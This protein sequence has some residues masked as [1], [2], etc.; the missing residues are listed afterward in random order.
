MKRGG[1]SLTIHP[2][3]TRATTVAHRRWALSQGPWLARTHRPWAFHA[4]RYAVAR[5]PL[6]VGRPVPPATTVPWRLTATQR[7]IPRLQWDSPGLFCCRKEGKRG[8]SEGGTCSV[9]TNVDLRVQAHGGHCLSGD[10]A[11]S[12]RCEMGGGGGLEQRLKGPQCFIEIGSD[13]I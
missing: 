6:G 13:Q 10:G 8:A 12:S 5:G 7:A 9:C 3:V 4:Q 2:N 11:P 1:C